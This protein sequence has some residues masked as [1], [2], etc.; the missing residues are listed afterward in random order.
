MLLPSK[1]DI[2]H[3]GAGRCS[4]YTGSRIHLDVGTKALMA[5]C[6]PLIGHIAIV[7]VERRTG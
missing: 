6:T 3:L 2:N 4:A 5:P 7:F 1:S